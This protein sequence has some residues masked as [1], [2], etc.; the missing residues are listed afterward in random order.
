[1]N[2][3]L[4][5]LDVAR[6]YLDLA[7]DRCDADSDADATVRA[8]LL[9][10]LAG[11]AWKQHEEPVAASYA[12]LAV[13]LLST[14]LGE[15]HLLT[16]AAQLL[17]SRLRLARDD[18]AGAQEQLEAAL[19]TRQALLAPGDPQIAE[20]HLVLGDLY[21]R[22]GNAG[23]ALGELRT[24]LALY[25]AAPHQRRGVAQSAARL[26]AVLAQVGDMEGA[27]HHARTALEARA[28]ANIGDDAEAAEVLRIL[29]RGCIALGDLTSGRAAFGRAL[30]VL[31]TVYGPEAPETRE[32][33]E[34]IAQLAAGKLLAVPPTWN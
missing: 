31:I 21:A 4:G 26:A 25:D 28:A 19:A 9:Q 2:E 20:A 33:R 7:F 22:S 5:D 3:R 30:E 10:R 14:M 11:V 23:L 29:G 13:D 24:A 12:G 1:V 18:F 17:H 15:R 8:N 6:R 27:V 34:Q 16:A 32:L